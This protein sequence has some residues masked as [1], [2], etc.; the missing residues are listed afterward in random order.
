MATEQELAALMAA[1]KAAH[2]ADLGLG[3]SFSLQE[4]IETTLRCENLL[5]RWGVPLTLGTV[6]TEGVGLGV[7]V[8]RGNSLS[9]H[10]GKTGADYRGLRLVKGGNTM[11]LGAMVDDSEISE[12]L[13]ISYERMG[14]QPIGIRGKDRDEQE[15]IVAVAHNLYSV[16][17]ISGY[18]YHD[19]KGLRMRGEGRDP[20]G[21]PYPGIPD[22]LKIK[23]AYGRPAPR[24]PVALQLIGALFKKPKRG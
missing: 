1:V 7:F 6:T 23:D 14:R 5:Q 15:R 17:A 16:G 18:N 9:Y 12:W 2:G 13:M 19:F 11:P 24:P 4:V 21:N 20:Q 3:Y 10:N 22:R 8:E